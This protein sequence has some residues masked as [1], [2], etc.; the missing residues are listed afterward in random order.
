MRLALPREKAKAPHGAGLSSEPTRGLEPR[1]PSLRALIRCR[2][3][4]R[5][6]ARSRMARTIGRGRGGGR[7]LETA[8][9]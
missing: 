1:T 7:R 8:K 6:V 4:A 5:A 3:R 9:T 2:V